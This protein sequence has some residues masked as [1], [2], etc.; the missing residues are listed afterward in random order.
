VF[1]GRAY[2]PGTEIVHILWHDDNGFTA[3]CTG[4]AIGIGGYNLGADRAFAFDYD[5]TGMLDHLEF[6]RPET[7]TFWF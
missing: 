1:T 5:H 7:G 6:C 3:V 4:T 2:R